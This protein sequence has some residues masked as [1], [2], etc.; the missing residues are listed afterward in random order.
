MP[1]MRCAPPSPA[2]VPNL[3]QNQHMLGLPVPVPR[4]RGD[5]MICEYCGYMAKDMADLK[6][7]DILCIKSYGK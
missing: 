4:A 6:Q 5:T 1:K 7:H 2:E 3:W